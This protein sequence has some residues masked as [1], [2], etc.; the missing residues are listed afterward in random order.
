MFII[1]FKWDIE[2]Y[3]IRWFCMKLNKLIVCKYCFIDLRFVVVFLIFWMWLFV[4]R[5]YI[6]YVII[7]CC[8]I[9]DY[10]C[11]FFEGK[12]CVEKNVELLEIL[13]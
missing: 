3:E 11:N 7:E 4:S 2:N 6:F 5:N 8:I 13:L 10:I 1:F 12:K 9:Y